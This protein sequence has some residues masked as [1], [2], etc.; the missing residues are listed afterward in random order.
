[1]AKLEKKIEI[2]TEEYNKAIRNLNTQ[3]FNDFDINENWFFI[4]LDNEFYIKIDKTGKYVLLFCD[5]VVYPLNEVMTNKIN[6]WLE[7]AEREALESEAYSR[8]IKQTDYRLM[9]ERC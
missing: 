7:D 5:T 2:P 8:D 6:A 4:D 1:M 9:I 3:N